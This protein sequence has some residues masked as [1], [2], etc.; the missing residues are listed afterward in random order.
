MQTLSIHR[1]FLRASL[2]IGGIFAWT[3]ILHAFYG[4]GETLAGALFLT[5]AAYAFL[6]LLVFFLTPLS[7]GNMPHGTM[8][9]MLC[10]TLALSAAFL[11]LAAASQGIFAGS[12]LNLWW[13]VG[14]FVVLIGLYRAF[15][16]VP[17]SAVGYAS[18]GNWSPRVRF[19]LEVLLALM[20]AVSALLIESR[21]GGVWLMLI[22]SS[23]AAFVAALTLIRAPDS[24]ERF[25]WGYAETIH[26]LFS[27]HHR[28]TFHT[29]VREGVQGASLLLL[30]PLTI[31]LAFG[32]YFTLGLILSIT[33]LLVLL[34]RR[35]L[36]A[37]LRRNELH[38][39]PRFL[40]A[41][42]GTSWV[43]RLAVFSPITIVLGDVLHHIGVPARR[44]GIDPVAMEQA[45]DSA[46][47]IDEFTALKEMGASLGRVFACVLVVLLLFFTTPLA[48]LTVTLIIIASL[49]AGA[50]YFARTE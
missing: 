39:N 43:M 47:Y 6:Q 44:I 36:Q 33:L 17:Y 9:P 28:E 29:S 24:Y 34:L 26:F 4:S 30:W 10:A 38:N 15:Y 48:A 11:W 50:Q 40:S 19:L 3:L 16:W 20:P 27:A 14:G 21:E 12:A 2:A 5:L 35:G 13:G 42:V 25:S 32:S 46:H 7:S 18:R 22:L 23:V 41:L 45:A 1:F 8:R 37:M 49:A 31:F